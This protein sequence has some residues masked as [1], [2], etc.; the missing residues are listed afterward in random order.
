VHD[1]CNPFR[2][3][4]EQAKRETPLGSLQYPVRLALFLIEE[5]GGRSSTHRPW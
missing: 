5:K 1:F 4:T 3:H 2:Y